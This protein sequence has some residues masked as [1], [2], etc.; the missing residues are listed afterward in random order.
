MNEEIINLTAK[1][2]QIHKAQVKAVLNLLS[3]GATVPFIA[4]YRKEVTGALNEDQI[5]AIAKEY[6]YALKL[7]ERKEDVI[8][9]IEEKG[10]MNDELKKAILEASKLTEV[11]DYYRPYKE[12]KKTRATVAIAKGLEP[13]ANWIMLLPIK[14]D[15]EKEASQ[16]I[17]DDVTSIQEAID[18]A[19]DI[20]AEKISDEVKYRQYTKNLINKTGILTTKLKKNAVD[21]KGIYAMYYEY[22]ERIKNLR[23]HRIL[24]I[25]RGEKEKILSVSFDIDK[26]R[27]YD[28]IN[29]SIV[30]HKMSVVNDIIEACVKDAFDR[31][32]RPSIERE[33]RNELTER[34]EE[35]SLAL[36][37][38]NLEHLLMQ[39]PLKDKYVL[40]LD[41]GFRTGCKLAAVDPTGK[42][43]GI[44]KCYISLPNKDH[45]QDEAKLLRMIKDYHIEVIAMGNGTA[46]RESEA[47]IAAFIKKYKLD[48]QYV[49]VS[50]AGASVYS[51]SKLAK[52]E[53]PDFAVEERSAVSIARRLQ[54]PLAELVK[55]DPK[56][57][58]VGQYQH[59]MN[60]KALGEQLDFVV[61]KVVNQVGVNINTASPSLL[62]YVSGLSA[63]TAKSIVKYREENGMF[64]QRQ[65]V[66]D[67]PKLGPKTYEQAVGF[68]RIP[69][70]LNILDETAIH[71]DN[72]DDAMRFLDYLHLSIADIGTSKMQEVLK[73]LNQ[74][75]AREELHFSTYLLEDLIDAFKAP[76]RSPRDEYEAPVLRSDVL[77]LDDLQLNM[78]LSGTVRNVVDFGAFVDIGLHEDGLV[79]ISKMS[80]RHIK[81]PLEVVNVG[82]IVDVYVIDIDKK[83]NRVGLSMIAS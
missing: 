31:L 27:F 79:H 32:I 69:E 68:L 64:K 8:R 78:K 26:E 49:I 44:D 54:D 30:G 56:S 34:A 55:I 24:A 3:E 22:S 45:H 51:A 35:K 71:P 9:L 16:Y 33:I 21:E 75:Q 76:S 65:E 53:F 59:D 18:G 13:L 5:R 1:T 28:Y 19:K 38:T 10:M 15:L 47:W 17:N 52:E 29:R 36:F 14:G 48:V 80:K 61:E 25:N 83:R 11:E 41:P 81:H 73:T 43:L 4:R 74:E 77:T 23:E 42:V 50:E 20:I 6:D 63:S 37:S 66:L 58:S 82:D 62:R 7:K 39:A 40:G 46:S 60:Q 70:G 57:I 72:Y 2:L 67:V 12:K